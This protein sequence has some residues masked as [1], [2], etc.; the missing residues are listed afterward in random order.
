[1]AKAERKK[2]LWLGIMLLLL[3]IAVYAGCG[4][5]GAKVDTQLE[6]AVKYLSEGKYEEA[7]L[8]YNGVFKIE[9]NNLA[10]Y[11]GLGKTY[12]LLGNSDEAEKTYRQGIYFVDDKEQL[13]LCLAG[14]YI[15]KKSYGQAGE[16]Y[17]ELIR[18]NPGC[19]PAYEGLA[20]LLI[21]Q[22]R[23]EEAISRLLECASKNADK[24]RSFSLLAEVYIKAG[25]RDNALKAINKSLE[26]SLNQQAAYELIEKLFNKDWQRVI[27]QGT[28][29]QAE[30]QKVGGMIKIYGYYNSGRYQDAINEFEALPGQDA[31]YYKAMIYAAFSQLKNNNL[32]T[33][34]KIIESINLQAEKNPCLFAD[35]A[36]YYLE[37]GDFGKAQSIAFQG[38]ELDDT[39]IENY[40]VLYDLAIR[41]N[42]PKAKYYPYLVLSRCTEPAGWLEEKLREQG[43]QV[44]FLSNQPA[45]AG[46]TVSPWSSAKGKTGG[47]VPDTASDPILTSTAIVMDVSDSMN[48]SWQGGKKISSAK[49]AAAQMLGLIE[50]ESEKLGPEHEVCVVSFADNASLKLPATPDIGRAKQTVAGL[51]TGNS[52]NIGEALDL[53]NS[54]LKNTPARKKIIVLLS[55]GQTNRGLSRDDIIKG[56]VN[57]AREA[58]I[59]IYTIGF[60][61]PGALDEDL[62]R[63][64]ASSTGGSYSNAA[65]SFDLQNVY[66][67]V[68]HEAAGN[69]LSELKGDIS[70]GETREIG[71]VQVSKDLGQLHSTLNWGGSALDLMLKDPRGKTVDENYPGAKVFREKPA[72]VIV[73]DPV[74]GEWTAI[75]YG[76]EVPEKRLAYDFLASGREKEK[77]DMSFI[78]GIALPAGVLF[79]LAV[80]LLA[81]KRAFK[82]CCPACG[83]KLQPSVPYCPSCGHEMQKLSR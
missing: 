54:Q 11:K 39:R 77:K 36:R 14:L 6:T 51:S 37:K 47:S 59:V 25:D 78:G 8:A 21:A 15:D 31:Q 20:R 65:G 34:D 80:L 3:S 60:G 42:D 74:P 67:K 10:A 58:G 69:I 71:K 13:K 9:P 49:T 64:I 41:K 44:D 56:P 57:M 45:P 73:E 48:E 63:R 70:Q 5:S 1:M 72:Y 16:A 55:D 18:A 50:W 68:R 33:A 43:I 4:Q 35:V 24:E 28:R 79:V 82:G 66:L 30:N 40:R 53:A 81:Y 17:Y 27:E 61:S 19:I 46:S 76:K 12:A 62:L 32:K 52:T 22:G 75:A 83:L 38:I 2:H 26:I 29:S 23:I 7:V